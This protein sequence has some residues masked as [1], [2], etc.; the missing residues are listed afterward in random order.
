MR[1]LMR[2]SHAMRK[3]GPPVIIPEHPWEGVG[4]AP[5]PSAYL[6]GDVEWDADMSLYRMWYTSAT[7]DEEGQHSTL[8]ATSPDGVHWEKPRLGIT[9]CDGSRDNNVLLR[10]C[11]VENV[12]RVDTEPDEAKRYQ[13]LTY[14]RNVHSYSWRYS[15]DG[16]RWSDPVPVPA[17]RGMW[18]MVNVAYDAVNERYVLVVKKAHLRSYRH[19]VL[20][21]HPRVA[22]RR[23]FVASS[24]DGFNWQPL[25]DM[26]GDFD[27]ID[28]ELYMRREGCAMLNTYGVSLHAYDG[29]VLGIQWLFRITDVEGFWGCHGGPMDGR[30]LVSRDWG[31]PWMIPSREFV[32]PRG[33]KGEFDC[34]CIMGVANRPVVSPSGDEWW[35]YYGGWDGGHGIGERRG[36]VGLAKLRAEGFCSIT[37]VDTEGVLE[38]TG[39]RFSG[40]ELRLNVDSRGEDTTAQPNYVLVELCDENGNSIPGLTREDCDGIHVDDV[41]HRVTWR[42]QSD[43]SRFAGDVVRLRMYVRGAELYAFGFGG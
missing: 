16:L 24:P 15:A 22:F 32:L 6:F 29:L 21:K 17:L 2:Q 30:L 14:D 4:T 26:R 8:Y 10:N 42:G 39:L 33:R 11:S 13:L 1:S 18:D 27:E 23:W 41:N 34:G 43:V 20:G 40:R 37:S 38:T 36:C 28:R 3:H 7:Q 19:P 9:D 12:L 31:G 25:D 35:Y 5:W